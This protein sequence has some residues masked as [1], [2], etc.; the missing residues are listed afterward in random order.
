MD[1]TAAMYEK[2]IKNGPYSDVA[3]RA[4]MNIGSAREKQVSFFNRVDPFR[5][6]VKAYETA[7]DRYRDNKRSRPK[8]SSKRVAPTTNRRGRRNTTRAWPARPSPRSVI[9]TSCSRATTV[10]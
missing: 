4:Q 2:L 7:A 9:S 10:G 6:A 1:K 5:E 3:P 8:R